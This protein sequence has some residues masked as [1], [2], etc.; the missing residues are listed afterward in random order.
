MAAEVDIRLSFRCAASIRASIGFRAASHS[1]NV[2][3][4]SPYARASSSSCSRSVLAQR[5]VLCGGRGIRAGRG[6]ERRC[7]GGRVQLDEHSLREERLD[8][9][10]VDRHPA[11]PGVTRSL[12]AD[13]PAI[14]VGLWP[15][16]ER[17]AAQ[18]APQQARQEVAADGSAAR[19]GALVEDGPQSSRFLRGD[20]RLPL[21]GGHDLAEVLALG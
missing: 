17:R 6:R 18:I 4:R 5:V 15:R 13:V 12:G 2:I 11:A 8:R 20:D 10:R 19:S 3:W 14:P 21:A 7:H 9:L 1:G 16:D